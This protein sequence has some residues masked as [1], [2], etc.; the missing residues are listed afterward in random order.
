MRKASENVSQ[1]ILTVRVGLLCVFICEI[2]D[3]GCSVPLQSPADSQGRIPVSLFSLHWTESEWLQFLKKQMHSSPH[4]VPS[5]DITSPALQNRLC[6]NGCI[7]NRFTTQTDL[8]QRSWT[9]PWLVRGVSWDTRG[10]EPLLARS[11]E[12]NPHAAWAGRS[13]GGDLHNLGFP[14]DSLHAPEPS[15]STRVLSAC[16]NHVAQ[17]PVI[18]SSKTSY[19]LMTFRKPSGRNSPQNC[20]RGFQLL[21]R[22]FYYCQ[23]FCFCSK[24]SFCLNI[25]IFCSLG[26]GKWV[27]IHFLRMH[28][29]VLS[30][31]PS[32]HSRSFSGG[33][34]CPCSGQEACQPTSAQALF[35]P[36]A[37]SPSTA[38]LAGYFPGNASISFSAEQNFIFMVYEKKLKPLILKDNSLRWWV[39][40]PPSLSGLWL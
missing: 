9:A 3:Q 13:P 6:I 27:I 1:H 26:A 16:L 39:L 2:P 28:V 7:T 35:H 8:G 30:I 36:G 12:K 18:A 19:D 29:P 40:F 24:S 25:E 23:S 31:L 14:G 38:R 15:L 37:A 22:R 33:S 11:Q 32:E 5:L 10:S 34:L 21:P 4:P 20:F 17:G